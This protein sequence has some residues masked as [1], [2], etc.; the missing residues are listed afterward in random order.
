MPAPGVS[1]RAWYL[2]LAAGVFLLDQGSKWMVSR[3]LA[4]GEVRRVIPGLVNLTRVHNPGAAFGLLSDYD[5]DWVTL[6]LVAFSAVALGLLLNLL[7]RGP[8]RLAG[9]GLGLLCGG[10][11]GNLFDRL[12]T[13]TVVDFLDFH[14]AGYHWPAFNLADGAIVLGAAALVAE[15]LR[16]GRRPATEA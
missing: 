1:P 16:R 15:V 11:V 7:W 12:R 3:G 14:L 9:A 8:A 10:A 2:F 4:P 5:S 6:V 13:G